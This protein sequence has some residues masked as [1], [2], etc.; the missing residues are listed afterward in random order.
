MLVLRSVRARAS[1]G[2]ASRWLAKMQERRTPACVIA[3][4]DELGCTWCSR[5]CSHLS[6]RPSSFTTVGRRRLSLERPRCH[7]L[8]SK[9][10]GRR[11][12]GVPVGVAKARECSPRLLLR[13]VDASFRQLARGVLDVVTP[14]GSVEERVDPIF[15]PFG[16]EQYDAG[17]HLV[18]R[19]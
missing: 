18:A 2:P 1:L 3:A 8:G 16:R 12:E 11:D 6:S 13:G 5:G 19:A 17:A 14:K 15:L 7:L 9:S 4:S 10:A